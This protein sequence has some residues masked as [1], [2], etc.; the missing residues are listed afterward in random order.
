MRPILI[1]PIP[2]IR[3]EDLADARRL[4]GLDAQRGAIELDND[5]AVIDNLEDR[6][7]RWRRCCGL[8]KVLVIRSSEQP[9]PGQ[10]KMAH[11]AS[12]D[13]CENLIEMLLRRKRLSLPARARADSKRLLELGHPATLPA[14]AT[15][16]LAV[17]WL[18]WEAS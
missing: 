1:V 4:N 7:M 3:E 18:L 5:G 6:R 2:R 16:P 15:S 8:S 11:P 14:A 13:N 9:V 17:P 10:S 12:L